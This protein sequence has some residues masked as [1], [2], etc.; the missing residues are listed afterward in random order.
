MQRALAIKI[1]VIFVLALTMLIPLEMI[2]GKVYER[3]R[4]QTA[5]TQSVASSWTDAQTLMTPILVIPYSYQEEQSENNGTGWIRTDVLRKEHKFILPKNVSVSGAIST[6]TLM[7]GIYEVPVYESDLSFTGEFSAQSLQSAIEEIRERVEPDAE[8]IPFLALHISDSRGVQ[9]ISN[10]QWADKTISFI[11]GTKIPLLREGIHAP[12]S[13]I[14]LND[15]INNDIAFDLSFSLKGMERLSII[16]VGDQV[17][18]DIQSGWPHP[19]FIGAF[20]PT[21]RD[22]NNEGFVSKWLVTQFASNIH[23][24]LQRCEKSDCG[25]LLGLSLGVNL[26]DPVDV[27][28]KSE[29]SIKYGILYIGLTFIS[30]FLFENLRKVRIHPIQYGLVGLSIATFY[31]LLGSLSEHISFALSY[32]LATIAC[33][34]IIF[35]YLK[36]VLDGLKNAAW[37][38]CALT[39]LYA[40]LYVIIQAE[41]FALLM[42]AV[43]VFAMLATIMIITRK[44]NWYEVGDQISKNPDIA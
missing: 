7:R 42:G 36:F 26:I 19:E 16:P 23:D 1:L 32:A 29:R 40:L 27:Y 28:L 2:R 43:L 37:F 3:E 8:I 35:A 6:Q 20:L 44:I 4:Y 31:L 25:P 38:A 22:I 10:L 14:K 13:A 5:A 33:V 39:L 21:A 30:F 17:D 15:I 34:S 18:V 41:D 12:L 24:K 9:S 11:P